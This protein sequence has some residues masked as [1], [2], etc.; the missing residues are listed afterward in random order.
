MS[1]KICIFIIAVAIIIF[2]SA[3]CIWADTGFWSAGA[4]NP[5]DW[6]VANNWD[7]GTVA[8]G[9]GNDAWFNVDVPTGGIATINVD[10]GRAGQVIG[11]L[12]FLDSDVSTPGSYL[13]QGTTTLNLQNSG[14]GTSQIYV[15][16]LFDPLGAE[17]LAAEISAPMSVADGTSLTIV[18]NSGTGT[19]K[20][21]GNT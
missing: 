12:N 6:S 13:V 11:N 10:A 15:Y 20:L 7:G 9:D 1:N 19:L 3:Q 2:A 5:G 4:A 17:L 21:S 8:D 16:P 14:V 18:G